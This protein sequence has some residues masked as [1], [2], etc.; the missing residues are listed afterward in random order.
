LALGLKKESVFETASFWDYVVADL[1]S[2]LLSPSHNTKMQDFFSEKDDKK[3]RLLKKNPEN[4][5]NE[6][7]KILI[8]NQ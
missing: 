3:S 1:I 4:D 7:I 8:I 5:F 2:L 6:F